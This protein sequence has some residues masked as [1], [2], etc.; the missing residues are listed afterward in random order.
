MGFQI[1]VESINKSSG[2]PGSRGGNVV[3]T[4]A[5]GSPVYEKKD[6]DSLR[7]PDKTIEQTIADSEARQRNKAKQKEDKARK[8]SDSMQNAKSKV[9][10]LWGKFV[11]SM[12]DSDVEKAKPKG[13]K[14]P[15]GAVHE[16]AHRFKHGE[17]LS[18]TGKPPVSREQAI[19]IGLSK[20][21]RGGNVH[22]GPAEH[23]K[24]EGMGKNERA[25]WRSN[26]RKKAK[27]SKGFGVVVKGEF[28]LDGDVELHHDADRPGKGRK[29][30]LKIDGKEKPGDTTIE[31]D[32]TSK[33]VGLGDYGAGLL[34]AM[35]LYA[36]SIVKGG[37]AW[38]TGPRGGKRQKQDD[39]TWKYESIGTKERGHSSTHPS[40]SPDTAGYL[41]DQAHS[42]KKMMNQNAEKIKGQES[43]VEHRGG[44]RAASKL[45]NEGHGKKP[46]GAMSKIGSWMGGGKSKTRR[47]APYKDKHGGK[48]W[49]HHEAESE[50]H[51]HKADSHKK[52]GNHFMAGYHGKMKEHH[53]G[54]ADSK[55]PK[56]TKEAMDSMSVGESMKHNSRLR[57]SENPA[58]DL[59]H[60]QDAQREKH[61]NDEKEKNDDAHSNSSEG[62]K[63]R[64]EKWKKFKADRLG[65]GGPGGNMGSVDVGGMMSA[66]ELDF[67]SLAESAVEGLIGS[68]FKSENVDKSFIFGGP[69]IGSF[70]SPDRCC[71]VFIGSPYYARALENRSAQLAAQADMTDLPYRYEPFGADKKKNDK[72]D[73]KR[74][75]CLDKMDNLRAERTRIESD[76]VAWKAK[77]TRRDDSTQKSLG[78]GIVVR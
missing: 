28:T 75:A 78:F 50:V 2:G 62:R 18:N 39:G 11:D 13:I 55:R 6:G 49:Q 14:S 64:A 53:A 76:F 45:W 43:K 27:T 38:E 4:T 68:I 3:G 56:T 40:E 8:R 66:A 41:V 36:D 12:K 73:K 1:Y 24:V 59:K 10:N 33:A 19:A 46:E 63:E 54:H 26:V 48:S 71:S 31:H 30:P 77:K 57:H 20:E 61:K 35:D 70:D 47:D 25:K 52:E 72:D 51:G 69:G 74:N 34:L 22:V 37:G 44:E 16:Y 17:P 32:D 15:R 65:S 9:K 42:M 29:S 60:V 67:G 23:S 5:S 7:G 21:E 58:K